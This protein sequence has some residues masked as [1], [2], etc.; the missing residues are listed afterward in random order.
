MCFSFWMQKQTSFPFYSD[1]QWWNLLL[2]SRLA[3]QWKIFLTD[4]PAMGKTVMRQFQIF[5]WAK[6]FQ[7][8]IPVKRWWITVKSCV[9]TLGWIW[10]EISFVKAITI[11]MRWINEY[12]AIIAELVKASPLQ[13]LLQSLGYP[14]RRCRVYSC[15]Q[16]VPTLTGEKNALPI[17]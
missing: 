3:F 4:K 15:K 16:A 6:W 14:H 11:N 17:T 9:W 12:R 8:N 10:N 7:G 5:L 1:F 2:T 13:S